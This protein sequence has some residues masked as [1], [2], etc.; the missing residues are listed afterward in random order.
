MSFDMFGKKEEIKENISEEKNEASV[1]QGKY[2][3]PCA[4]CGK[5]PSDKKWAGNY[6]H[7]KCLRRAKKGA[8][9]MV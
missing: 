4:L 5:G 9:K 7:K 3:E 2:S 8:M 1:P 6:W